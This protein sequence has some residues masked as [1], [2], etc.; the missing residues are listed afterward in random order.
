MIQRQLKL[1]LTRAQETPLGEWLWTLTGV[2]NWAIRKIELDA[3]DGIFYTKKEF[4]NLL[5]GHGKTLG[6]PSHTLQ[7]TLTNASIAWERCF[8]KLGKRP[9]LK[10]QR[11]RLGSIPVPAPIRPPQGNRIQVPGLGSVRFH[12]QSLPEGT[13]KSGRI[14]KRASGWYFCLFIDA[15]PNPIEITGAEW[16][17]IDPGFKDLLTLSTG[18]KI[19]HPRE[20]EQTAERLAQ[21]QRGGNKHLAACLQE[22]LANQRKDRNHKRSRDLVSQFEVIVFSKDT[23]RAIARTFGKS[24]A[25]SSHGQLRNMLA[26]K[27]RRI[28]NTKRIFVRIPR[29]GQAGS[30]SLAISGQLRLG[31]RCPFLTPPV[32]HDGDEGEVQATPSCSQRASAT[33]RGSGVSRRGARRRMRR[34][35]AMAAMSCKAPW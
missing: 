23:H 2:W 8:K 26:Y 30:A 12:Q 11:N 3:N 5:A 4:H 1:R 25:S 22:R 7:G 24:V 34:R 15:E 32:Q 35:S 29:Y 20:L 13:I 21:A 16:V 14:V 19:P 27:C 33:G 28:R 17:G 9:K 6:I 31:P 18:P 10:G